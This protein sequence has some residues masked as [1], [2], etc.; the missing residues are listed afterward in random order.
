MLLSQSIEEKSMA[1]WREAPLPPNRQSVMPNQFKAE[2]EDVCDLL[3]LIKQ[4]INKATAGGVEPEYITVRFD[5][6]GPTIPDR[7]TE[8]VLGKIVEYLHAAGW[9]E[10]SHAV[11][12][13]K[14]VLWIK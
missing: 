9:L 14:I 4:E 13:S 7:N 3:E 5:R 6:A 2:W 12:G 1:E 11:E 10:T 8:Y